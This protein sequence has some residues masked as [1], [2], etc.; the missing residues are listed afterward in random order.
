ME[1]EYLVLKSSSSP[2]MTSRLIMI[3]TLTERKGERRGENAHERL[4]HKSA[5]LHLAAT[6][7]QRERGGESESATE[8][9]AIY[10]V[11]II[12]LTNSS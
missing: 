1:M 12:I 9:C 7:R 4:I 2:S 10:L 8:R 3:H 6:R 5:L 11:D